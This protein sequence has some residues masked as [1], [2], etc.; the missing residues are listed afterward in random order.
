MKKGEV[1]N[2]VVLRLQNEL[3][4][5]RRTKT[6]PHTILEGTYDISD[7]TEKYFDQLPVKYQ[8]LATKL[9]KEYN[10]H[11]IKNIDNLK[12]AL[13][14]EYSSVVDNLATSHDSF[15]FDHVL[16]KYRKDINPIRALYYEVR[17]LQRRYDSDNEYHVWLAG[18]VTDKEYNNI[19]LDALQKDIS[20]LERIVK[21]FYF[22]MVKHTNTMPLELVHAK[23]TIK[24]FR[25]FYTVFAEIQSWIPTH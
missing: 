15:K 24:D 20:K 21:R 17:E 10:A 3:D 23:S 16:L 5:F 12:I 25:H 19:I 13:R 7:L 14:K 11:V 18:L 9:A 8:R 4:K 1:L 22:P 2:F 6:I